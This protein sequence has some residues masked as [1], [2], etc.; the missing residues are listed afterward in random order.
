MLA[1]AGVVGAAGA[2]AW[3]TNL[4]LLHAAVREAVESLPAGLP[5]SVAVVAVTVEPPEATI[6]RVALQDALLAHGVRVTADPTGSPRV[7]VSVARMQVTIADA[8][9]RW[10]VGAR[11][12][13]RN[14]G[15]QTS[16]ALRTGD[17][18][19]VWQVS[20]G[21]ERDDWIPASALA[22]ANGPVALGCALEA[23]EEPWGLLV[24]PVIVMSSV[25][26][27]LYLFF[28]K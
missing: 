22:E 9:R 25:A 12:L 14:A 6:V 28:T 5:D 7:H 1:V 21:A 3:P 8:R 15:V 4:E 16:A 19:T 23:P 18:L 13:Q 24:E 2:G 27:V 11:R 17:G 26:A 10:L 20:A